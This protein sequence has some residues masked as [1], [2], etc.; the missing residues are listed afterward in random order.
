[1]LDA[2]AE[3]EGLSVDKSEV[4]QRIR[5]AVE[6]EKYYPNHRDEAVSIS[7]S[8]GVTEFIPGEEVAIF[9]QR[10]D[11]AMYLSKQSGRN[12]VS[13]LFASKAK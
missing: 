13:C 5:S 1:M 7:I 9:V 10:A 2:V 3:A 6:V 11:K 8:I 4:E 12:R